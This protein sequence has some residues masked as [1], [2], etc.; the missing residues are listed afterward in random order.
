[1]LAKGWCKLL[2]LEIAFVREVCVCV[3]VYV[4]VVFVRV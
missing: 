2:F 3:C 1:M 4:C